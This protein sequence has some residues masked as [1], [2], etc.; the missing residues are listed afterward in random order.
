MLNAMQKA[1]EQLALK[2]V[3]LVIKAPLQTQPQDVLDCDAIIL[4]TPENLAY[5]SGAL[6]DFFDR[7][8]YPAGY[9]RQYMAAVAIG[10]RSEFVRSI[11]V[12]TLV[13]HGEAD[14]LV[15]VTGGRDTAEKVTGAKLEVIEGMGHNLPAALTGHIVDLIANHTTSVLVKA[16]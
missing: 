7:C 2:N 15:P 3:E 8:Y 14:P 12:P 9:L 5:M 4:G 16:S 10:D 1:I 13:I 11:D 6:K